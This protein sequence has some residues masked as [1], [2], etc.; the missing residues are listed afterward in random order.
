MKNIF[1]KGTT[2]FLAMIV[3]TLSV[4]P[5]L[6]AEID[7]SQDTEVVEAD[8]GYEVYEEEFIL[9]AGDSISADELN[10]AISTLSTIDQTFTMGSYHRG[11]DRTYSTSNLRFMITITDTS[12][13][14]TSSTLSLGFQD[15]NGNSRG[16]VL[17]ADGSTYS[18]NNISIVA[19]RTYYFTYY[20]NGSVNLKVRMV[21]TNY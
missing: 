10:S 9:G 3:A 2:F 19:G 13:N 21:I 14:A 7:T 11:A 6:A 8:V 17:D 12:G 15:Y 4:M 16:W 20:N 5:A 18:Q 1:K